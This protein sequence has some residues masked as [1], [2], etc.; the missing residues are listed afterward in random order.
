MW[1][2]KIK[3][4]KGVKKMTFEELI[5]KR[6]QATVFDNTGVDIATQ[7]ALVD[8]YFD[9]GLC[10]DEDEDKNGDIFLRYFQRNLNLYYPRYLQLLRVLAVKENMD[11]YV[12]DYIEE[13]AYK[14]DTNTGSVTSV[15]TKDLEHDTVTTPQSSTTVLRT[16][17]LT[18]TS[19]ISGGHTDTRTP[20]VTN[21]QTS[22][23]TTKTDAFAMA[24]PESQLSALS[25]DLDLD[26]PRDITYAQSESLAGT[27]SEGSA[28]STE[29][30]TETNQTVY[31]SETTTNQQTGTETT[32][33]SQSGT[34]SVNAT[35]TGTDTTET[36][37]E[38]TSESETGRVHKGRTE[39]VADIL[40]RAAAAIKGS[41]AFTWFKNEMKVCFDLYA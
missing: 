22:G 7:N 37:N 10:T 16:P 8:W 36:T 41:D 34:D 35:D 31:N 12:T 29:T 5:N 30:G 4:M 27:K 2:K 23:N 24:Y 14:N 1:Q 6:S 21:T 17:T 9:Y 26:D 11:P 20:N 40:P 18:D 32:V 13:I 25:T 38:G 3:I 28:T 33:T 15:N 19:V 39:S